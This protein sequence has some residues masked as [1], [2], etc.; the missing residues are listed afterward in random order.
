MQD[1]HRATHIGPDA[2]TG[3]SSAATKGTEVGAGFPGPAAL[4]RPQASPGTARLRA[5]NPMPEHCLNTP[6]DDAHGGGED[7][8][9]SS[10]NST[11]GSGHGDRHVGSPLTPGDPRRGHRRPRG[12]RR[13]GT[14]PG[15]GRGH[16]RPAADPGRRQ[17]RVCLDP[18]PDAARRRRRIQGLADAATGTA[19][20]VRGRSNSTAGAG[21]VGQVVAT[22]GTNYGVRGLA[23]SAAGVGVQGEGPWLG[24]RGQGGIVGVLGYVSGRRRQGRGPHHRGIR[25]HHRIGAGS[26]SM[27]R[28]RTRRA[29]RSASWARSTPR[30]SGSVS[31]AGTTVPPRRH[32]VSTD[33]P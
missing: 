16:R 20:G 10:P 26:A 30:G 21:V 24:M 33:A 11:G 25:S 32:S 18:R 23:A 2:A 7:V 4:M 28:R 31:S 14:Q 3:G 9:T 19:Y 15:Q 5:S 12:Q 27:A 17:H 8:S 1:E 22:S 13:P 6:D 29:P